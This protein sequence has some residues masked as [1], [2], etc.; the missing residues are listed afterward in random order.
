MKIIYI[1]L[2]I[3]ALSAV[4]GMLVAGVIWLLRNAFTERPRTKRQR[5]RHPFR[6]LKQMQNE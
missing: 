1:T 4:I 6:D 3:Y 2:I 5:S